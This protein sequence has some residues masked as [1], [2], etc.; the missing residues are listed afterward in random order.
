MLAAGAMTACAGPAIAPP[1]TVT[2]TAPPATSTTAPPTPSRAD[3]MQQSAD[4]IQ[5]RLAAAGYTSAGVVVQSDDQIKVSVPNGDAATVTSLVGK[6]G[7]LGFRAVYQVAQSASSEATGALMLPALP[8][9]PPTQRPTAPGSNPN[10]SFSDLLNWQPSSQ[11]SRDFNNWSCGDPFPDV[12]DQPLFA[13]DSSYVK[14]LLGPVI[15]K[16]QNVNSAHAGIPWGGV[17]YQVALKLDP[18]GTDAFA[19]LTTKLAGQTSPMNQFAIV[20]DG[21]V[22]SAPAVQSAV[23]NGQAQITGSFTGQQ[24]QDLASVLSYGALPLRFDVASVTTV[25]PPGVAP[26]G[27][28][29][30][31]FITVHGS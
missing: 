22:V 4:I 3:L 2:V 25:A 21:A 28:I 5:H 29:L 13:C 19:Q 23:T 16:G 9:A 24:A 15:I 18:T 12:W 7:Q 31:V 10:T 11:D 26:G 27:P 8:T 1:V 20:V 30:E 17:A 6:Q 14:Y